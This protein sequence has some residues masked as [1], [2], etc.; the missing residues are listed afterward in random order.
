MLDSSST[1]SLGF[2]FGADLVKTGDVSV[3]V[4]AMPKPLDLDRLTITRG[5][6]AGSFL[7]VGVKPTMAGEVAVSYTLLVRR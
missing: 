4:P 3:M 7:V 5:D 1:S 2:K 6:M